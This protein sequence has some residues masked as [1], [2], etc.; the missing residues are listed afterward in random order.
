[1]YARA[2]IRLT[3]GTYLVSPFGARNFHF[4]LNCGTRTAP[5]EVDFGGSTL[6]FEARPCR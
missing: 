6:V 5:F 4:Y 1:V 3:K 2:G